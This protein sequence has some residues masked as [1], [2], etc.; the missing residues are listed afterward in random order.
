MEV[1]LLTVVPLVGYLIAYHVYGKFL[2]RKIFKLDDNRLVP[3]RELADGLDYVPTRKG[4]IFG[5]HY[6]SIAGTGPI[7]G[8]AIGI[9]WGWV[10][11]LI[12]V[13]VG[14]IVM[15]A[16][17]DLGSLV[18]SLRNEGKS[19]SD[20]AGPLINKRV[21]T[22][23]FLIV[24]FELWIVIAIFALIIGLLFARYPQSVFPI[25]M[26]IPIA[27]ALG[28]AIYKRGVNVIAAT[29]IA[30]TVMYVTVV[31]GHWL[32]FAMPSVGPVPAVSVWIVV[33]LAY[34]FVA[35]TLPVTTL[36]QPRDFI[37]A[38]QLFVAM[39]LLL[40]GAV[41]AST[42]G[43]LEIVAPAFNAS[44]KGAPP[45]WP[46]LFVTIACGAISGFHC[47]VASGTTPKQISR[48][49]DALFVG[50]GSML[51]EG[52]LAVLV[53]VA[54]AA[55]IG[56]HYELKEA[57]TGAVTV[58][59]GREAWL[60]HYASWQGAEGL[61]SKLDAVVTGSANMMSTF[62]IPFALGI[63]IMGVFIASFAGTT[64]DTATR[65]QRYVLSELGQDLG[66]V[67]LSNRFVATG[68][69]IGSAAALA[70]VTGANGQGA[71]RL[72]PMFGAV[73]QLLAALALLIVTV[74]LRRRLA[75]GWLVTA[76]PMLFMLVMTHYAMYLNERRFFA[77][78]EWLLVVVN[79]LVQVLA[80]WMTIEAII[81]FFTGAAEPAEVP[82][83]AAAEA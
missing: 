31:M 23:F 33:L 53:L 14:S 67:R 34:A 40:M 76:L 79:A 54:V 80:I 17:H 77:N 16:V 32:P 78:G 36:L 74:Y 8:P 10:P 19:L 45:L 41:A 42:T 6:T 39:G 44:P 62:G 27:V 22:I 57:G 50:Y 18:V 68:I 1:L 9:I 12:W 11:A 28:Y 73:N 69:A 51:L 61:T 72:W 63:I 48:E 15:G 30:V 52:A 21:R 81:V 3:S 13:F 2:A 35:S 38:W 55:G 20:I 82:S 70:F 56:M 64:L 4:I 7:V 59:A 60:T 75:W 25:W 49:G 5:H 71:M 65:I 46:F 26:E 47:L 29:A 83:P 37:N 66:L 58:L 24:F 43:G